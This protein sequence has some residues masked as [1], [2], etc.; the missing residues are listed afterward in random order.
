MRIDAFGVSDIFYHDLTVV[1][2]ALPKSQL[3]KLQV[4]H[5]REVEI[6]KVYSEGHEMV[7]EISKFQNHFRN[8]IIILDYKRPISY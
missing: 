2:I 3:E 1:E 5:L 7:F 4:T 6:C 8:E